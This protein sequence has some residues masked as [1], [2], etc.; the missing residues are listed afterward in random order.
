MD[1]K[2]L[3]G[4][5]VVSIARGEKVGAVDDVVIDTQ[6]RRIGALR[7]GS[8]GLLRKDRHYVPFEAVRSIGTDAVMIDDEAA[9]QQSYAT[10]T[11]GYHSLDN[12]SGLRVVTDGGTYLGNIATI[13]FNESDGNLTDFE[14]GQS[15]IG[16]LF[17]SSKIVGASTIISI[18]HDI[19]IVPDHLFGSANDAE[20]TSDS[21]HATTG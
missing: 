13:H 10:R 11:S 4:I 8:G 17:G 21:S 2:T 19:M 12:I 16:G 14:I 18:G 3:K 9:L 20:A 7:I 5:A 15:G 1:V 6:E